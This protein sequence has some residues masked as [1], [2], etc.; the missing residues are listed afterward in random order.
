MRKAL[1][2]KP[3]VK[4]TILGD[5]LIVNG[6]VHKYYQVPSK[7]LGPAEEEGND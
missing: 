6:R 2:E 3:N 7:W 5:R 1:K 4:A